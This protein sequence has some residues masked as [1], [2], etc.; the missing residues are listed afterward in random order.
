MIRARVYMLVAG[1]GLLGLLAAGCQSMPFHGKHF[2]G[3]TE[4]VAVLQPT[5]GSMVTGTVR[6]L[7]QGDEVRIVAEVAG[8]KPSARHA[9]HVHEFGDIT[10]PDGTCA[11]G[12]YNPDGYPHAGPDTAKRHAGDLGNLIADDR[13]NAHYELVVDNLSVA[14]ARNPVIGRGIVVH[15]GTDDYTTQPT[16]NAGARAAVGVIG[17]AMVM[18]AGK[19]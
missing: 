19:K 2:A 12:H 6:F 10:S 7:Q 18:P 14:G 5:K 11:G 17:I 1:L 8:L 4:A 15:A 16:G 3:V 13:G 9:M